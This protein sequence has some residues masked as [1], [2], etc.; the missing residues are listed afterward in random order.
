MEEQ[1]SED[2]KMEKS[3]DERTASRLEDGSDD[4]EKTTDE[5]SIRLVERPTPQ[6]AD[7]VKSGK[8]SSEKRRAEKQKCIRS[9]KNIRNS[10]KLRCKKLRELS[11]YYFKLIALKQQIDYRGYLLFYTLILF[12]RTKSI[13]TYRNEDWVA[14]D[15]SAPEIKKEIKQNNINFSLFGY[16][17][18]E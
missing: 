18:D 6:T 10:I 13:K 2:D 14:P 15:K 3:H 11:L 1:K 5:D 7:A 12:K 9:A 17:I 8:E 16:F 4:Q